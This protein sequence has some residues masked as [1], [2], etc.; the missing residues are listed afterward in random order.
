MLLHHLLSMEMIKDAGIPEETLK[1]TFLIKPC[2]DPGLEIC[3]YGVF[4]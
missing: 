3:N 1:Q 2:K 4:V